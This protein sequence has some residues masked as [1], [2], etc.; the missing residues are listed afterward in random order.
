M[1]RSDQ[2]ELNRI[3]SNRTSEQVETKEFLKEK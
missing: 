1:K 2:T 3:E